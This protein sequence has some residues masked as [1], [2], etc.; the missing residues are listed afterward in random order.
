M[1]SKEVALEEIELHR[2]LLDEGLSAL[3]HSIIFIRAPCGVKP[4]DTRCKL[5]EPLVYARCGSDVNSSVSDGIKLL[6]SKTRRS[7]NPNPTLP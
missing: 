5:L 3:L 4:E 6:G 1:N 7:F 2:S